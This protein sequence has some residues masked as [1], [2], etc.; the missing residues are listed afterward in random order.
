M[1]EKRGVDLKGPLPVATP[2]PPPSCAQ[3]RA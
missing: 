2:P 1:G 3:A